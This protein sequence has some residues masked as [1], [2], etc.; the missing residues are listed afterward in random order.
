M[1]SPHDRAWSEGHKAG[2]NAKPISACPYGSGMMQQHWQA[3][4]NAGH[5]AKES[6]SSN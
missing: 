2:K 3:G 1:A 6:G 4:W 5:A